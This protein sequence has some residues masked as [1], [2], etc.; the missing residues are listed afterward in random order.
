MTRFLVNMSFAA[1][2]RWVSFFFNPYKDTKCSEYFV[3]LIFKPLKRPPPNRWFLPLKEKTA[4]PGRLPVSTRGVLL[5]PGELSGMFT[6]IYF[7][8]KVIY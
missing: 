1:M 8:K 7:Y 3:N 2:N 6:N 5:P 4:I